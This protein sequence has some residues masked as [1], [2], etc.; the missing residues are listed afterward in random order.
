MLVWIPIAW[1]GAR[2][3]RAERRHSL[4]QPGIRWLGRRHRGMLGSRFSNTATHF[5]K[6]E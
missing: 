5:L 1:V 3:R 6:A 4:R 2:A